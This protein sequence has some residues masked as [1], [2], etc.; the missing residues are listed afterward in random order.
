MTT[1]YL[2]INNSYNHMLSLPDLKEKQVLFVK[3]EQGIDNNLKIINDNI[4]LLKDGKVQNRLS[5]SKAL[6]VFIVGEC[7]LTSVLIRKSLDYGVS[8][9]LLR[10]S[11][12]NYTSMD[13]K[14]DGNYLLRMKQYAFM[15]ELPMAKCIVKNKVRNDLKLLKSTGKI[16]SEK[17]KIQKKAIMKKIDNV[18]G[19]KELLG[20]EGSF[21]KKFFSIYFEE[22][23]WYKRMPRTKIDPYN[24]LLDMGYTFMFNYVDCLLNLF[25]FDTYKG[26]YHKLYFQRKS[27]SCDRVEPC[28]CLIERKLLTAYHLGQI[29][30]KDFKKINGRYV[31]SYDKSS[32]YAK[33][34]LDEIMDNKEDIYLYIKQF[35]RHI[36]FED[37]D[38]PDFKIR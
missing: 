17:Y 21:A 15:E 9:F 4:V 32:K 18:R 22:L 8:I 14:A 24:V 26:F 1:R 37:T 7:T 33:I 34:F 13:S 5:C 25:G 36:M 16:D 10:D 28:R 11:L 27:L 35:Y 38:F 3:T 23:D 6:A 19:E 30:K 29:D 2:K 12:E 31:L 20:I